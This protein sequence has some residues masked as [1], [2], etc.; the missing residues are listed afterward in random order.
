VRD[1][2]VNAW[3]RQT[4]HRS[5]SLLRASQL[6][7]ELDAENS[8][9]TLEDGRMPDAMTVVVRSSSDPAHLGSALRAAIAGVDPTI[10]V[11]EMKAMTDIVSDS[12]A[13]PRSTAL[14]F[15]VFAGLAFTLGIIGIYGVLSFLVSN[16]TREL[17]VRMALGA[18]QRQVLSSVMIEGGKFSMLGIFLGIS[19][20]VA[21]MRILSSELYGVSATDPATFASVAVL[22][23]G[24]AL[25]ACYIPARRAMHVDPIIALRYE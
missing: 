13:S 15:S 3:L 20:A 24:V 21:V 12:V 4:F 23:A 16:R 1:E 18:Q 8:R 19:G 7:S 25:F 14:L 11:G 9:A 22:V 2:T 5:I 10:P 6:D 17:G